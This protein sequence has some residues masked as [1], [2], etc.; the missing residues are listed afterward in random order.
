M[1]HALR[2]F[3]AALLVVPFAACSDSLEFPVP[4]QELDALQ[5]AFFNLGGGGASSAA[6]GAYGF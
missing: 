3:S 2:C 6:K 4:N 5:K 1:R